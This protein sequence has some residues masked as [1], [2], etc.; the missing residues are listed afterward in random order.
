MRKKG[1]YL[2]LNVVAVVA[3]IP[4]IRQP[5]LGN[6]K[7]QAQD[8]NPKESEFLSLT[9]FDDIFTVV[10]GRSHGYGVA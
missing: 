3:F 1:F 4:R 10:A 9:F 2:Q 7:T 5:L 8:R 6:T